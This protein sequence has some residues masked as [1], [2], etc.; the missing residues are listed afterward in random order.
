M[1]TSLVKDYRSS[2]SSNSSL[3][4][5]D[6]S[7]YLAPQSTEKLHTKLLGIYRAAATP[8]RTAFEHRAEV[9]ASEG[10]VL[11]HYTQNIDGRCTSLPSLLARTT[12]LHGRLD[13]MMC[14]KYAQYTV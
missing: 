14:H 11:R 5:F 1:L 8:G 6:F 12:F 10:R 2:R 3:R 13:I 7:A 9:L 4:V